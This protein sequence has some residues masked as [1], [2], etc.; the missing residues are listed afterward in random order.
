MFRGS[1]IRATGKANWLRVS[2]DVALTVVMS[3]D[4]PAAS[5]RSETTAPSGISCVPQF[6][7]RNRKHFAPFLGED[8]RCHDL[9]ATV[10]IS[11]QSLATFPSVIR[12]RAFGVRGRSD[13]QGASSFLA[14]S[15]GEAEP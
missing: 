7:H 6:A 10:A 13:E 3:L 8:E 12:V 4:A 9:A 11:A 1:G 2:G 14:T 15:E 5:D